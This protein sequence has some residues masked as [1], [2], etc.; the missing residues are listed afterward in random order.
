MPTPGNGS[1]R[2]D[3]RPQGGPSQFIRFSTLPRE[4][5]IHIWNYAVHDP[6][7]WQLRMRCDRGGNL[8]PM[9]DLH[10]PLLAACG[11]SRDAF[12][13]ASS[14]VCFVDISGEPVD[15]S[16]WKDVVWRSGL[17]LAVLGPGHN[18]AEL[19]T[20]EGGAKIR[21]L[22]IS[23]ALAHDALVDLCYPRQFNRERGWMLRRL[24]NLM[25]WQIYGLPVESPP[26]GE[27]DDTDPK[28]QG[29]GYSG[30]DNLVPFFV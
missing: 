22:V 10:S 3:G 19:S 21:H 12:L 16:G 17:R 7:N 2:L 1:H 24:P 13:Q 28:E 27:G 18:V 8:S 20:V 5:Q 6:Q 4:L 23:Y 11:A 15:E 26:S 30:E 29:P 9:H 25:S 14:E